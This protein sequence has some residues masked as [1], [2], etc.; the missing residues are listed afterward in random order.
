V[1]HNREPCLH[2]LEEI[3]YTE[4][5]ANRVRQLRLSATLFSDLKKKTTSQFL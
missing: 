4:Q 2:L 3:H 5:C 1:L